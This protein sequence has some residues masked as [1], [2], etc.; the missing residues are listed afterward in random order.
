MENVLSSSFINNK[1]LSLYLFI[2]LVFYFMGHTNTSAD[3]TTVSAKK[4]D[5]AGGK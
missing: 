2:V 5:V 4:D 1:E 3:K